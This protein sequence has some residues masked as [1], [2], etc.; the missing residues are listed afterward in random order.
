VQQI[1]PTLISTTS[2]TALTPNGTLGLN[3]IGLISP[4]V[5]AIQ[6]LS[7]EM[8]NLVATVQGFA[9]SFSSETIT[10]TNELC[11]NKSDGTPVCIT[12]DQLASLLAGNGNGSNQSASGAQQ[13][14]GAPPNP[15]KSVTWISPC[16]RAR[17]SRRSRHT[18]PKDYPFFG[19]E[20]PPAGLTARNRRSDPDLRSGVDRLSP[21]AAFSS[22]LRVSTPLR[23]S[24]PERRPTTDRLLSFAIVT[25]P[26]DPAC[27]AFGVKLPLLSTLG[28]TTFLNGTLVSNIVL[29]TSEVATDTRSHRHS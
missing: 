2:A 14:P 22:S 12:G 27:F 16:R 15:P 26:S 6:A 23:R 8:Q 11:V 17:K 28:V 29:D 7:T 13:S 3:Y 5:S 1:F 10:A 19:V 21:I 25:S 20:P 4:I 18:V 24:F 9:Q